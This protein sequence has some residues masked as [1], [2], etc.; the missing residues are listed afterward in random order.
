M[1][2][3]TAAPVFTAAGFWR[4]CAGAAV[5]AAAVVPVALLFTWLCGRLVGL[6]LPPSRY[7]GL[8]FWLDLVLTVDPAIWATITLS[9][10]IASIYLVVFQAT[11]GCTPGMRA[12]RIR[13]IDVYGEPPTLARSAL[14][15]VGYLAIPL[16]LGL[17]FLWAGFDRERRGLH[18][19]LAGTYVV[20]A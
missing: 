4:R 19:W 3:A 1:R 18:D 15:T 6:A 11:L 5:D 20:R 17:G 10:T 9:A 12:V 8:D 16:T 14:R 2:R 7:R 13:V